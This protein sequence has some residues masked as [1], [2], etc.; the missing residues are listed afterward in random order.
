VCLFWHLCS[1]QM[2]GRRAQGRRGMTAVQAARDTWGQVRQVKTSMRRKSALP[3]L[4]SLRKTSGSTDLGD[5]NRHICVY[6]CTHRTSAPG[7]LFWDLRKLLSPL[8]TQLSRM[9]AFAVTRSRR[10]THRLG[11]EAPGGHSSKPSRHPSARKR[12]CRGMSQSVL[13][14]AKAKL[15]HG[16]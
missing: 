12:M 8:V 9:I 14:T 13:L 4:S 1:R 5:R 10:R 16:T 7:S 2:H 11:A 3:I 6:M 15:L